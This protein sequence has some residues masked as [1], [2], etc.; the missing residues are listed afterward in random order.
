VVTANLVV[1]ESDRAR[2]EC[3]N[4]ASGIS[5]SIR[6][7]AEFVMAEMGNSHPI[8]YAPA[9]PGDVQRFAVDNTKLRRLGIDFETDWRAVVREVMA[10]ERPVAGARL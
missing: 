5:V 8:E 10:A 1:A 7:L 3:F 4:C 2:G 9:R 6:E